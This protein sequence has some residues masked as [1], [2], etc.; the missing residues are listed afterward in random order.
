MP[1]R[2]TMSGRSSSPTRQAR[3]TRSSYTAHMLM[4]FRRALRGRSKPRVLRPKLP[5]HGSI[6]MRSIGWSAEPWLINQHNR[7]DV[8][9]IAGTALIQVNAQSATRVKICST[10]GRG[11]SHVMGSERGAHDGRE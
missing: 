8:K 6:F 2:K 9:N 5:G 7:A 10:E 11:R 3:N 1:E 4:K